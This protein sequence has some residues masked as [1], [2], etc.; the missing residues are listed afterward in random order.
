MKLCVFSCGLTCFF[1][2]AVLMTGLSEAAVERRPGG[3]Y[4]VIKKLSQ[5]LRELDTMNE[6]SYCSE[7]V[8]SERADLEFMK[9]IVHA[10]SGSGISVP[11]DP[12]FPDA[13]KDR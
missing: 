3:H 8:L 6:P 2:V 1:V 12:G 10:I 7:L 11:R 9:D 4:A 13:L 5:M